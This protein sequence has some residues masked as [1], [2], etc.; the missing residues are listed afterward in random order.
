MAV[1]SGHTAGMNRFAGADDS[2]FAGGPFVGPSI[3]SIAVPV[4]RLTATLGHEQA[5]SDASFYP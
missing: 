5:G 3:A 1:C 2:L 4:W